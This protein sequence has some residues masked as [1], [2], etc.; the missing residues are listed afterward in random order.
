MDRLFLRRLPINDDGDDILSEILPDPEKVMVLDVDNATYKGALC[1]VLTNLSGARVKVEL[2]TD[3]KVL[4]V[5]ADAIMRATT[6]HTQLA[7]AI[8]VMLPV[9][10]FEMSSAS[11]RTG[12]TRVIP[13]SH[14]EF[15]VCMAGI[16][17]EIVRAN[18][19]L[20]STY[21][22]TMLE[23]LQNIPTRLQ[24]DLFLVVGTVINDSLMERL[25]RRVD[26]C[27]ATFRA[28]VS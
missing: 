20:S 21:K 22:A 5:K 15:A 12:N 25:Q 13:A 19:Q 6:R 1:R 16:V 2:V 10:R 27:V 23:A 14:G 3:R 17:D 24:H 11:S 18:P 26:A 8:K 9:I 28:V 4:S 7:L